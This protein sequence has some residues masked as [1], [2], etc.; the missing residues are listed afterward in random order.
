MTVLFN[1]DQLH[2]LFSKIPVNST[3]LSD[4]SLADRPVVY[5]TEGT[6]RP[7]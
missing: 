3:E 4:Q 5:H 1:E 2:S 7:C 6:D